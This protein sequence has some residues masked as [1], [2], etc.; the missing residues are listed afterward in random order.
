MAGSTQEVVVIDSIG[1]Q[2]T[3]KKP[4]LLAQFQIVEAAGPEAAENRVYMSMILPLIYVVSIDGLPVP[5][6]RRK[7]EIDALIQRL[8]DHGF[9]ALRNGLEE[10]FADQSELDDKKAKVKE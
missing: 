8:E 6:P 10:H 2:I 5:P 7:S 9:L 4:G 1:R 3:L